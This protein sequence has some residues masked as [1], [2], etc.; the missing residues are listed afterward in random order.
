MPD[1]Q[2]AVCKAGPFRSNFVL[3]K[4]LESTHNLTYKKYK[5]RY[6]RQDW[7]K[8]ISMVTTPADNRPL[9]IHKCLGCK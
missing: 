6:I 7:K 1:I 9:K 3:C 4:H 2:C 5:S 8:L